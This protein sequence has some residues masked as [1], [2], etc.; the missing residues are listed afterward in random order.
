M[1]FSDPG[2][3]RIARVAL[4]CAACAACASS[5][6]LF[7]LLTKPPNRYAGSS[8]NI[9]Q[10][11]TG[12]LNS[13]RLESVSNTPANSTLSFSKFEGIPFDSHSCSCRT[14]AGV[15]LSSMCAVMITLGSS[16]SSLP[17]IGG[18]VENFPSLRSTIGRSVLLLGKNPGVAMSPCFFLFRTSSLKIETVVHGWP[19]QTFS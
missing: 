2:A 19:L 16:F 10:T 12:T 6:N 9:A 8:R 7:P 15:I 11:S 17:V 4:C 14:V 5:S 3:G 13:R 1:M 18:G